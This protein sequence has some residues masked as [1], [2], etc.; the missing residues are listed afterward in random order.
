MS[1]QTLADL[2]AGSYLG[3]K[4]IKLA[5]DD[6]HSFPSEIL[7]LS[8][9]LEIL[10]L[11]NNPHLSTLP[12]SISQLTNLKIAFFSSCSFQQ[13]PSALALCPALEMVAFKDN[14]MKRIE[15]GSLPRKLR[16]LI[17]TGN[18]LEKLPR[19][20]AECARLEKCMLAGNRLRAIPEGLRMCRKLGLLRVACNEIED[21]PEW[22]WSMPELAFF[23]VAGNP[24]CDG[25]SEKESSGQSDDLED[26]PWEDLTVQHLLGKGASGIISQA[27]WK[28]TSSLSVSKQT[29]FKDSGYN[30][31]ISQSGTST[32]A[33]QVTHDKV[34][35]KIFH[36]TLTSD[37]SPLSE[38]EACIAVG[39]HANVI[40][41]LGT[42][43][44]HPS[45]S[46]GLVLELIPASY[47]NL[48]LP[49]SFTTCTRD[50]F[51][52]QEIKGKLDVAA[53]M[54]ILKGIAEAMMHLHARNVAHG[55]LYAHNILVDV[56]RNR[57]VLG[58]F[59]AAT[60]Y[61]NLFV[62]SDGGSEGDGKR[63]ERLEVLAFAHLVEDMIGCCAWNVGGYESEGRLLEA[64]CRLWR[65]CC[66]PVVERRPGFGEVVE[67][68]KAL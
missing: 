50:V 16:W 31:P 46:P 49:P 14:G 33:L 29:T 25:S 28:R 17:L 45:S 11:S 12:A 58:D 2:R 66:C 26:I 8:K 48:G 1:T 24:C 51:D 18:Q 3:V 22:I 57:A 44:S 36:G 30:T 38:L 4:K 61:K 20:V 64:L 27:L 42:I 7:T 34:A 54:G 59:G 6:L 19:D 43:T 41:S 56:A 40:S 63:Y 52:E 65:D 37:G 9:T 68:L 67:A 35:I 53:V 15:E 47:K 62:S 39:Q 10:D 32:P 5:N 13:F 21:V 60:L 23:S 55:D